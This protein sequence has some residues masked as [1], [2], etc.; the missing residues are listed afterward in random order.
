[1][2]ETHVE[3]GAGANGW[4]EHPA[5]AQRRLPA[6]NEAGVIAATLARIARARGASW[7]GRSKSSS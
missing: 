1:M 3:V 6:Y 4:S 5:A 7:P 2:R